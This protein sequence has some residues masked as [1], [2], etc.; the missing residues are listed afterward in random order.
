MIKFA[1]TTPRKTPVIGL[2]LSR[3]NCERL[4][5]GQP[6][7]IRTDEIVPELDAE[8]IIF[9]GETEAAMA[10]EFKRHGLIGPNTKVHGMHPDDPHAR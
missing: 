2:G 9:A 3:A 10:A 7:R 4:L 1:G 8:I 6:I 5:A